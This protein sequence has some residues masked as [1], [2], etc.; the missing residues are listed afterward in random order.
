MIIVLV[1]FHFQLEC[2]ESTSGS[3][4][5]SVMGTATHSSADRPVG[6]PKDYR[7]AAHPFGERAR[8]T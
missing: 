8:V 7:T 5:T 3:L 4:T 2:L 6:R 1:S